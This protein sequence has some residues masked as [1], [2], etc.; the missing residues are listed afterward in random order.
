[1]I[2]KTDSELQEQMMA[3]CEY[4]KPFLMI[5]G[6]CAIIFFFAA[7]FCITAGVTAIFNLIFPKIQ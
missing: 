4:S 6:I 5:I 7:L 1:M 3:E 2:M